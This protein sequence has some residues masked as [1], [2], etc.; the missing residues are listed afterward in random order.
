MEDPDSLERFSAQGMIV[1]QATET[2]HRVCKACVTRLW[3]SSVSALCVNP[4]R[5]VLYPM[6]SLLCGEVL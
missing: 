1:T 2:E 6:A 3:F 5:S 4:Q